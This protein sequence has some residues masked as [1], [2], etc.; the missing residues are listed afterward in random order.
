MTYQGEDISFF[1]EEVLKGNDWEVGLGH[2]YSNG[3]IVVDESGATAL[4]GFYA[5]GEASSG[6]FGA[7]RG[8]RALVEMMVQGYSAGEHAAAYIGEADAP[9]VNEGEIETNVRRITDYVERDRPLRPVTV[10]NSLESTADRGFWFTRDEK[11]ISRAIFEVERIK[12][13][14]LPAMSVKSKSRKYNLDWME[15]MAVENLA[16]CLEA[17]LRAALMRRES[18]GTHIRRDRPKVDHDNF[19]FRIFHHLKEGE[20]VQSTERPTTTMIEPPGGKVKSVMEYI[21]D[22]E[23]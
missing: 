1:L 10:R 6:C 11:G 9:R 3:G 16:L 22:C 2:E 5:A 12:M 21:L 20:I 14:L 7:Y 4:P 17:G 8:H 19:L 23:D 18:R 15:A 13:D